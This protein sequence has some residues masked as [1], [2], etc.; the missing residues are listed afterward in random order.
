MK[1]IFFFQAVRD[2]AGRVHLTRIPRN[3][4]AAPMIDLVTQKCDLKKPT[5]GVL[6]VPVTGIGT[7]LCKQEIESK[8]NIR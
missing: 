1:M 4:G 6:V 2:G 7:N 5:D 8:L 3:L